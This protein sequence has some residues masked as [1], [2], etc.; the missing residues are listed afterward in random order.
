[1][2]RMESMES[3]IYEL[4]KQ[5]KKLKSKGK[6]LDSTVDEESSQDDPEKAYRNLVANSTSLFN[7]V[8]VL[9]RKIFTREEILSHSVSGKAAN[10]TTPAKPKFG[11]QLEIVRKVARDL[12]GDAASQS[13]VTNKIQ[14]VQKAVKKE[15]TKKELE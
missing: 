2:D 15:E 11:S 14:A 1:M 6:K 5:V 4:R 10:S 8:N 12:H 9:M 13:A 3:E 7:T